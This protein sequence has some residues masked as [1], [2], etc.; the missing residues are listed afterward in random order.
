MA[1]IRGMGDGIDPEELIVGGNY[2]GTLL[3]AALP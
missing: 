2:D 3:L 1:T